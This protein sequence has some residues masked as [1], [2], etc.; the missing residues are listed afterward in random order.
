MKTLITYF[1]AEGTT[2]NVAKKLAKDC[3]LDLFEIVPEKPYT[4]ADI[5]WMNPLSRCN[6]EKIGN[7]DVP[8][9]GKIE[10]F[11]E[12]GS[13]VRGAEKGRFLYGGSTII[14]LVKEDKICIDAGLVNAGKDG[15]EISV[16]MGQNL[17]SV[18]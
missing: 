7:K 14:M 16:K 9:A 12:K 2:A 11:D 4:A 17:G 6:K 5:K 13:F 3:G 10:N 8:V 18:L 1:S 15:K